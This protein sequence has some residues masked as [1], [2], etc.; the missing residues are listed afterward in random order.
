MK[1]HLAYM[2]QRAPDGTLSGRDHLLRLPLTL[3]TEEEK[4]RCFNS[5]GAGCFAK[6]Q[7]YCRKFG[8][9]DSLTLAR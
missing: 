1:A 8:M 9:D 3:Q 7:E 5:G 4:R 2:H 6:P